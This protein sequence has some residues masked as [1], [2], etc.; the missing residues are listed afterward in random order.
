MKTR[1][2]SFTVGSASLYWPRTHVVEA[3]SFQRLPGLDVAA[4]VVD[5]FAAHVELGPPAGDDAEV[6]G[7][8]ARSFHRPD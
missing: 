2:S 6:P 5:L 4:E 7:R 3:G 8:G 1:K